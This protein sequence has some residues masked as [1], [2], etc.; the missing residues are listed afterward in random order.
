MDGA[1]RCLEVIS[2]MW[3][4]AAVQAAR[5]GHAIHC[6]KPDG[7]VGKLYC[8]YGVLADGSVRWK[9]VFA[10]KATGKQTQVAKWLT[11]WMPDER[12][13]KPTKPVRTAGRVVTVNPGQFERQ[14]R[15]VIDALGLP[16]PVPVEVAR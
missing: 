3:A 13:S 9:L 6:H 5:Q 7:C 12:I 14:V 15:V 10:D 1:Y 2:P 11:D 8:N 4:L 16:Y